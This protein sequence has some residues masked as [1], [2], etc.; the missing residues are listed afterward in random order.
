MRVIPRAGSKRKPAAG[1]RGVISA[2]ESHRQTGQE[3]NGCC[4]RRPLEP[5]VLCVE[6]RLLD[7]DP[8]CLASSSLRVTTGITKY[9]QLL[10]VPEPNMLRVVEQ[11]LARGNRPWGL[12]VAPGTVDDDRLSRP[13]A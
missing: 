2:M 4:V 13:R 5:N 7:I 3:W 8:T 9:N 1:N 10:G 11:P 6:E 12:K